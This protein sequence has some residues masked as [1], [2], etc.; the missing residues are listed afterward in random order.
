MLGAR[1]PLGSIACRVGVLLVLAAGVLPGAQPQADDSLLSL[2]FANDFFGGD[3]AHF[4]NGVALS[5]I[6][7]AFAKPPPAA[8][9]WLPGIGSPQRQHHLNLIIS[10]RL[11]TPRDTDTQRPVRDDI[12]YSAQALIGAAISSQDELDVHAWSLTLGLVGPSARGEELQSSVHDVIGGDLPKGWDN[13]L[14]DAFLANLDYTYRRRIGSWGGDG[15]YR[16]DLLA[17]GDVRLGNL[18]T[19]AGAGLALRY[20]KHLPDHYAVPPAFLGD[21]NLGA[22]P[23][24]GYRQRP[25]WYGYFLVD[26]ATIAHAVF[27]DGTHDDDRLAVDYD[28]WMVR[29]ILGARYE[30]RAWGAGLEYVAATIPWDNPNGMEFQ[31]YGRLR[32]DRRF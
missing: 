28:P 8:L 31:I 4:T 22:Q 14:D 9:A 6:S 32:I 29:G 20:G 2:T 15:R 17:L 11:F 12:P 5:W 24:G 16:G 1:D 7:P 26:A 21:P 13:Q 3:D 23:T 27:L 30:G 18:L 19:L 25:A 10:H